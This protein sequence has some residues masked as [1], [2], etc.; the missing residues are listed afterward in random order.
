V[1]LGLVGCG[2]LVLF[3][4]FFFFLWGFFVFVGGL[5]LSWFRVKGGG[6]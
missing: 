1:F 6:F 5:C 4:F 3:F 2:G